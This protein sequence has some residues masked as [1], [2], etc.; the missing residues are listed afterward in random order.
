MHMGCE[1]QITEPLAL[2]ACGGFKDNLVT[3]SLFLLAGILET[4]SISLEL[5]LAMS[6]L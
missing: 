3:Q 4:F 1:G 5:Q 6:V 2:Y